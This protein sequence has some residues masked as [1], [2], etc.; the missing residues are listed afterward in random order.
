MQV[1]WERLL[2]ALGCKV[3]DPDVTHRQ[4]CPLHKNEERTLEIRKHPI[5][6]SWQFVCRAPECRFKGDAP[7]LVGRLKNLPIV[8][9]I[10]LFRPGREFNHTL[11]EY[12]D[13][14]E[15]LTSL[16]NQTQAL[17]Y[18]ASCQQGMK[19]ER[20]RY[21]QS[22]MAD[23][24]LTPTPNV[25]TYGLHPSIGILRHGSA[26]TCLTD[27][28]SKKC[29]SGYH[30]VYPYTLDGILTQV[31]AQ[32]QDAEPYNRVEIVLTLAGG[33]IF[34]EDN[35]VDTTKNVCIATTEALAC[36]L[37]WKSFETTTKMAVI[38]TKE[39]RLPA[40]CR[41]IQHIYIV[42]H[43]DNQLTLEQALRYLDDHTAYDNKAT[44][45]VYEIRELLRNV[46]H[47]VFQTMTGHNRI[48]LETWILR[49][50]RAML[51]NAPNEVMS[52]MA[53]TRLND[54]TREQL[55]AHA[56]AANVLLDSA[57][58]DILRGTKTANG[59]YTLANGCKVRV[60][61][62][63][64]VG[65]RGN[66]TDQLSNVPIVVDRCIVQSNK[67]IT[68]ECRV[69][70]S[71]DRHVKVLIGRDYTLSAPDMM[72]TVQAEF[73]RQGYTDYVT[74]YTEAR[75]GW[76]DILACM[77][78]GRPIVR[79]VDHLGVVDT[80]YVHLPNFSIDTLNHRPLPQQDMW[81]I[82]ENLRLMYNIRPSDD[83]W[84]SEFREL[85]N[86]QNNVLT[87][88]I[89]AGIM[90]L[91]YLQFLAR[92]QKDM[93]MPL[94]P[95]HF[96]YVDE[97]GGSAWYDAFTQLNRLF[98]G[99]D[100]PPTISALDQDNNI[101]G[102][103]PLGSLPAIISLP[104]MTADRLNQIVDTAPASI[105]SVINSQIASELPFDHRR[106]FMIIPPTSNRSTY[107]I[108]HNDMSHLKR[109]IG[110]ILTEI[111]SHPIT[112]SELNELQVSK[113]GALI[114]YNM[115]CD[116]Y[117]IEPSMSLINK[118]SWYYTDVRS[119]L[120][121]FM[122]AAHNVIYNQDKARKCG[123]ETM[124]SMPSREW[125]KKNGGRGPL[126][127]ELDDHVLVGVRLVT[128]CNNWSKR[129]AFECDVI[130]AELAKHNYL[131]EPPKSATVKLGNYWCIKRDVWD[132]QIKHL[133]MDLKPIIDV[134][135]SIPLRLVSGNE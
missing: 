50:L 53:N 43:F 123:I 99:Y 111:L 28:N 98:S 30:A 97:G 36:A 134:N 131:A 8:Q 26:P 56:T 44:P 109:V 47:T 16:S 86:T 95:K 116:W 129:F 57:V 35:L 60:T 122:N 9:A 77:A 132:T 6:D 70:L 90:H 41:N 24:G 31:V 87:E 22:M 25:T 37:Y 51:T 39:L 33:G 49:Q 113:T 128:L 15:Y 112:T 34:M 3:T 13:I 114:T 63:G 133:P 130:S 82:N 11:V 7:A 101:A 17:G 73:I 115:L 48:R 127:I 94:T 61:K 64:L 96:F 118:L 75:L 72:K 12:V 107:Q 88:G 27:L 91:I 108:N 21:L 79:E 71:D 65:T 66:K 4:P 69:M 67:K 89:V 1:Y 59:L 106:A 135:D 80:Q 105:I 58:V 83:E 14:D 121:T 74:F 124:T 40:L 32:Q 2:E 46:A 19:E 42:S 81:T 93:G 10:D 62:N 76:A 117:G 125:L 100:R 20:G 38:C 102:L 78:S 29:K 23:R 5:T 68:Y 84:E 85:M 55:V 54:R 104:N 18:I 103:K 110:R 126:V 92:H 120:T 45:Y 119:D 52:I